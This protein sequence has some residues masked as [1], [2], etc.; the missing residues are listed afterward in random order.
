MNDS[1]WRRE[2]RGPGAPDRGSAP[3]TGGRASEDAEAR[4]AGAGPRDGAHGRR[5]S[6]DIAE[7]VISP[8]SPGPRGD[9]AL[10]TGQPEVGNE[11]QCD[12]QRGPDDKRCLEV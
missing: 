12:R 11:S 2:I 9:H 5:R 3:R 4:I 1:E 10:K 8:L 7:L 6:V